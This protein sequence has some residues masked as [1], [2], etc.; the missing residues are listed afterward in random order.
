MPRRSEAASRVAFI[1]KRRTDLKYK[2]KSIRMHWVN[3]YLGLKIFLI[4]LEN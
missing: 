3:Y 1:P 4:Q 2:M